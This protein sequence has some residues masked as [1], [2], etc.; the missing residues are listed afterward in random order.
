MSKKW[1]LASHN[2]G[3][4]KEM[5]VLLGHLDLV[6]LRDFSDEPPEETGLTFV[7]NAIIKARAAAKISG[8]PAIADDSGLVVD[9]L[10]GAPGV[11]S[12]RYA[13]VDAS[14]G[15]NNQKLLREMCSVHKAQRSACYV[16]V[17]VALRFPEDPLPRIATGV[18]EGVIHHESRGEN[19]F[20]YDPIFW[21]DEYQK[22]VA[23][24]DLEVKNE[25]SHRA[26]ACRQLK[27]LLEQD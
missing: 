18:W 16:S 4:I 11:F 14:Y 27:V 5:A 24:L 13:G 17:L 21:I 26:I 12:A 1:V 2:A 7:E 10:K 19:G 15:D 20:G 9:A 8:L 3:K 6:G 22:T 25:V 23:E